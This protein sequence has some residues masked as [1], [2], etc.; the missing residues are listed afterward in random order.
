MSKS[1]NKFPVGI[2]AR[3][4]SI[5]IAFTYQG[6]ECR[7]S[8]KL[9]PT[10]ANIKHAERKRRQI[11]DEIELG[12]FDYAKHF[13]K[14][15][16]ARKHTPEIPCNIY[17]S[18]LLT[19]ERKKPT[20][21]YSTWSRYKRMVDGRLK[22]AFGSYKLN[23]LTDTDITSWI[24]TLDLTAKTVDNHLN[25]LRATLS[26]AM[27]KRW[28]SENPME[29]VEK[30]KNFKNLKP[31]KEK[32]ADPF[33]PDEISSILSACDGTMRNL[34]QFAFGTGL[35]SSELMALK[36]IDI[37]IENK[38]AYIRRARV[39][40]ITKDR[41]K[42][43]NSK[44]E[45][46]LT[47]LAINSLENQREISYED[48]EYVFFN[49]TTKNPWR[50]SSDILKRW[51]QIL[52]KANVRYRY[53]YQT[54][55]TFASLALSMGENELFVSSQMGHVDVTMVRR[56]YGSWIPEANPNSG[57]K[58]DSALLAIKKPK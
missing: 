31:S 7:H 32:V 3:N 4:K 46:K 41:T 14:S 28:I 35:R 45:L 57:S 6:K 37:E 24:S 50:H 38:K 54:R 1:K 20:C 12:K 48:S 56:N 13:P 40:N 11:I 9:R 36:W 43:I 55:H 42:T 10:P 15:N 53:A 23:E 29:F 25:L 30:A 8:L 5:Q 18:L 52:K 17:E 22:E 27:R 51:R 26:Y 34:I 49:P 47:S 2:T 21:E 39:D 16:I 19:L 33:T 58:I 44:R